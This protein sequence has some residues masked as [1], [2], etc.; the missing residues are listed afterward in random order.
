MDDILQKILT[1]GGALLTG[2]LGAVIAA[3]YHDDKSAKGVII[4]VVSGAI[5]TVVCAPAAVSYFQ[6]TAPVWQNLIGFLIGAFGGSLIS[7]GVNLIK[8]ADWWGLVRDII[9]RRFGG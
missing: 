7:S 2:T 5:I 3:R 1:A 9:T 4:F 8:S 6:I